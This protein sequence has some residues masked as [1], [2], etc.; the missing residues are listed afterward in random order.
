MTATNGLLVQ[1]S[2]LGQVIGPPAVGALAAAT[3]SW[4]AAPVVL[5][6]AACGGIGAALVL[7]RLERR[8]A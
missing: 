2:N 6:V 4:A 5:A 7:R 3:G 8:S 1:G